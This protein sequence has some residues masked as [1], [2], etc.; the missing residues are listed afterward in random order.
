MIDKDHD[1][2]DWYKVLVYLIIFGLCGYLWFL[3]VSTIV[4]FLI[5]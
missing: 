1:S 2:I 4:H 5:K 3:A